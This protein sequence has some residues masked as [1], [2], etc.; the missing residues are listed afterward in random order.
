MKYFR[1][2][3]PVVEAL[4]KFED[5]YDYSKGGSLLKDCSKKDCSYLFDD[6]YEQ[7]INYIDPSLLLFSRNADGRG[8]ISLG[9]LLIILSLL[10]LVVT[11]KFAM[12]KVLKLMPLE[13]LVE[14]MKGSNSKVKTWTKNKIPCSGRLY[15][16][17][18]SCVLLLIGFLMAAIIQSS[19]LLCSLLI[20][21]VVKEFVSLD[22]AYALT[23][24][25][26]V[27]KYKSIK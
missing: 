14:K 16:C 2:I 25:F 22:S 3:T 12:P 23:L 10:I 5:D 21:F 27:G 4:V 19:T 13:I 1:I 15:Y 9:V 26:N 18:E 20:P 6:W 7:A 17:F 8:D 11:W 24:G